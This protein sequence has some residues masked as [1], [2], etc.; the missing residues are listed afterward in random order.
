MYYLAVFLRL[1]VFFL[2]VPFQIVH[3]CMTCMIEPFTNINSIILFH[4][5]MVQIQLLFLIYVCIFVN[6]DVI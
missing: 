2:A 4:M 3:V 5:H 1:F 6:F